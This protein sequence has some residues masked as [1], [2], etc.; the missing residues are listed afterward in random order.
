MNSNVL[1]IVLDSVRARNMSIYNHKNETTPF[2]EKFADEATVYTQARSPATWSLPSHVSMFTGLHAREH[3]LTSRDEKL[4]PGHTFWEKLADEAGY[5]TG[6]F[7][8]N[9]F[10]TVTPV[11]L[12]RC[13]ETSVGRSDYPFADGMDPR[14]FVR[15]HGQGQYRKFFSAALESDRP[16]ASVI[17]G[18]YEKVDRTA[19]WLIPD[20]IRSDESS[21]FFANRFLDWSNSQDG[22]WAACI[23]FMDGHQ[24]YLPSPE[25][26]HWG[27]DQLR[28]LHDEFGTTWEYNGGKRPWWE[29]SALEALYDG[30]IREADAAVQTVLTG[31]AD[32]GELDDTLV[33]VTA[34]HGE[35]F[36]E[37]SRLRPGARAISHG[38]GGAQEV[39]LHVPLL[40]QLPGQTEGRVNRSICSLTH[41]RHLVESVTEEEPTEFPPEEPVVASGEGLNQRMRRSAQE[42]CSDLSLFT[43]KT[44]IYYSDEENGDTVTKYARWEPESNDRDVR[45]ITCIC[46]DSQTTYMTSEK[47]ADT[48]DPVFDSLTPASVTEEGTA[49]D[50]SVKRHL[51]ELGYA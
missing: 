34:D 7:S 44:R 37:P 3:R 43:G 27:G 1:L 45:E 50:A 28:E 42:E 38:N 24:P 2:L 39:L 9:P 18:L 26:D 12:E 14:E 8:K 49:V 6:V 25:Y 35:G 17:N 13:F 51:E 22:P 46:R 31:L 23:N 33:I 29:R 16:V 32:R 48:L 30:C 36:G 5:S 40:V 19:P 11:G 4:A 47:A 20:R 21:F 41:L 15:E 10:L